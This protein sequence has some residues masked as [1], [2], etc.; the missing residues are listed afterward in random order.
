M[1][2]HI[3]N[4][5][6]GSRVFF[7]LLLLFIPTLSEWFYI[8]YLVTGFTDLIDGTIARRLGAEST[9]G[10]RLDTA[11]DFT[12][13]I[14]L[15]IKIV[16]L[17][18]VPVWLWVWAISLL[19]IK[20]GNISVLFLFRRKLISMH[21]TLNR[22]TGGV[23]FIFPLSLTYLD[24]AYVFSAICVLLTASTLQEIICTATDKTVL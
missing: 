9:F 22:L 4:L 18:R 6:T 10:S 23:L 3:A 11:S 8:L 15:A 21:T 5:I 20:L 7:S 2:K 24:N 16:P 12:F 19:I 17:V 1:K 14:V 13:L